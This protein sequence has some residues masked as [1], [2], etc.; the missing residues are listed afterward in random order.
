[1]KHITFYLDFISPYAYLAFKALPKSLLGLSYSV[2]YKPVFLGGLLKH[3][4]KKGP[5]EFP[6][7]RAWLYRQVQW[8]AQQQGVAMDIPAQHP[9]NPLGLLRL[10]LACDAQGLPNRY[11]CETL[12]DH[13]WVGGLDAADSKRVQEVTEQLA[14]S[15]DPKSEAV[16]Q[17]LNAHGESAIAQ[18]V[19][20]VPAFEVDGKVF[21]GL[22]ALPMLRD[23]LENGAWF[24]SA[25]WDAAD[26]V[27]SAFPL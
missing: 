8:L 23:Y 27:D 21:W 15:R 13:V 7:Q 25:R 24:E 19:F 26:K 9:F 11:V 18:G 16:K 20:G 2:T 10:A 6:S 5:A 3:Y 12:F 4:Q 22:D 17:E 1:M 14:P